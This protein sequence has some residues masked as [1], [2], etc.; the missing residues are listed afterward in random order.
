[1]NTFK[2]GT[3][4]VNVLIS[5]PL[6]YTVQKLSIF[7]YVDLSYFSAEGCAEATAQCTS[8]VDNMFSITKMEGTFSLKPF[9]TTKT[10]QNIVL[11]QHLP[12]ESF[13]Y[14]KN[15]F[16]VYAKKVKWPAENISALSLFFWKLEIHTMQKNPLGN[17]IIL[18]YT[19]HIHHN[20]HNELKVNR[21]YDISIIN[22]NL[23]CDITFEVQLVDQQ[24]MKAKVGLHPHTPLNY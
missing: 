16:L 9:A 2:P 18:I 7:N 5:C 12:F 11:D 19:A 8:Q 10:S 15:N 6:Q 3:S 14:T 23:M 24:K 13:L 21:G 17:Q 20:W 4:V 1:M 22:D